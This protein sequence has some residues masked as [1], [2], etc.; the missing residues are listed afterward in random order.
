MLLRCGFALMLNTAHF[1]LEVRV[2]ML[3]HAHMPYRLLMPA[4]CST[5]DSMAGSC[6]NLPAWL[7]SLESL[8]Y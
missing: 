4:T 1:K 7:K 5:R 3:W 6:G 8:W 2:R